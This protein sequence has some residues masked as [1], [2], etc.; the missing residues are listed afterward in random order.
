MSDISALESRITA[1]LERIRQ[2][3]DR[4]EG[5]GGG[6]DDLQDA[7][8]A[9]R[10][11]NAALETRVAQLQERQDTQVAK[12]TGR[13]ETYQT[14]ILKLDEELQQLRAS[15]QQLRTLNTQLRETV[16][17]GLAPELH[18]AAVA[19]EIEALATQRSADAA[20]ID[21]IL[22]EL[23]PLIEETSNAAG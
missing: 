23:K 12:L 7:L 22:A 3:L 6:D 15:N 11:S 8:S 10:A 19:A 1:A 9:E 4:Q 5:G 20:E 21:A 13:I 18:D 14:Q 2:G 17:T 16:T